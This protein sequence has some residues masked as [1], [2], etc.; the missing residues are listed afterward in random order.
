MY[1]HVNSV[2]NN[3]VKILS[4]GTSYTQKT[5]GKEKNLYKYSTILLAEVK[6]LP[7]YD[8]EQISCFL[9]IKSMRTRARRPPKCQGQC[10]G[11][12]QVTE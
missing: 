2:N 11:R 4:L 6:V 10:W 1:K 9:C 7:K 5:G 12:T 8:V 3:S